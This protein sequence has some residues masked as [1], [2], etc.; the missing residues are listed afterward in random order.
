MNHFLSVIYRPKGEIN[1][2]FIS[3]KSGDF[4]KFIFQVYPL[5]P[6]FDYTKSS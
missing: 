5:P 2:K 6:S 1:V 4:F 3:S